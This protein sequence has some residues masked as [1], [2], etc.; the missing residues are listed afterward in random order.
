MTDLPE[1]L[2]KIGLE[3]YGAIFAEHEITLDVLTDLTE[4]DIDRLALPTGPRRQLIVAI[5]AL[6]SERPQPSPSTPAYPNRAIDAER[7]QL[8]VMFCDLAGFTA[9]AE[10]LDPEELRELMNTYRSV[11][12][13]IIDRYEGHVAQYLGDGLMVYFGWPNAHEDDAERCLRA[14]LEIVQAVEGM[15]VKG[16]LEVRIG[17]ATGTVVMGDVSRSAN[18]ETTLAVGETPNLA[19]RLQQSAEPGQIVMGLATRRLLGD[20]VDTTDLG[21]RVLD[22]FA[23]PVRVWRVNGLHRTE[24]RFEAAHE[25]LPL[26]PFVGREEETALLVRAWHQARD[27]EGRVVL[28]GGEPGIGKSRLIQVLRDELGGGSHT[29]LRY[30]CSPFHVNSMLYPIIEHLEFAAGFVRE[31]TADQ[32][33]DKMENVLLGTTPR[34]TE[35]AP[36]MA[37][38]LSLPIDRYGPLDLSPQK[39]KEKTLE[40]L[41]AHIEVLSRRQPLLMVFED[42]HWIDPSSQEALDVL[43]PRL[44][45][46]AVLLVI[47]HRPEYTLRWAQQPHVTRLGLGRLGRRHGAELVAQVTHGRTLPAEVLQQIVAHTDGVPLFIE[48]LTKSVLESGLLRESGIE[49]TL[50]TPL[51]PLAIPTSLRDSL[52]ARL[53]RLAPAKDIIQVGACIGQEFSHDL[54]ARISAIG[55]DVLEE[56]LAKLIE[57]G[58]IYRRGSPPDAIYTFK[59]ALMRDAAYDSLLKSRRVQLHAEIAR[60]LDEHFADRVVNEPER[61]AH[62]HTQSGNLT[63]AIPLWQKA[64]TLALRRVAL[65]EALAHFQNG[66]LLIA[67]LPPSAERDSLELSIREPLNLAWTGLRGWAAPEAADNEVAILDL[68]RR[69]NRPQSLLLGMW[70]MWSH[71]ITRG[72]IAD[73]LEWA[74]RLLDEGTRTHNSDMRIFG[75]TNVAISRFYLGDLTDARDQAKQVLKLYDPREAVRRLELTSLDVRTFVGVWSSQWTWMLGYPDQAVRLSDEK[76]AQARELSNAFNLGFV[77]TLGAYTFDYRSEP[78]RLLERIHEADRVAREQSIP[79]LS[80]VQIPMAE[81]LAWLRSGHLGEAISCLRR[82]IEHWNGRGGHIRI[83]YVKAALAEALARQGHLDSALETIDECL[84]QI[85]RPGWQERSHLAEVLRLKG[86]MLMQKGRGAEAEAP[87]RASIEWARRQRAKSWELRASTT[88]AELLIDRGQADAARKQLAAI[89]DWFTEGFETHDLRSARRM[90]ESLR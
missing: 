20:V 1:W 50:Q 75:H 47:T 55:D 63:A 15:G 61:L 12:A 58:L 68:A 89:Y 36:L 59:H 28:I 44:Q 78:E 16:R 40:A 18:M 42:A 49:Y 9:L 51:P 74:D 56:G 17:I 43:V 83:P 57:A 54:L 45:T 32:K 8:T 70:G 26:T 37:A 29:V 69:Q 48:E 38:L 24:G 34:S 14:A 23:T 52:L 76:D 30:Q 3:R 2:R 82:G 81:G 79:F 11:S 7:R 73:S 27:G 21:T 25:G 80:E 88:L 84:D 72:Q 4:S 35:S 10:R 77:L 5:R 86:W 31:D 53:D 71:T 64:G 62:H 65:Q 22:G 33:L 67:Q 41:A 39:Q 6:Q 60:T 19:A 85:E 13:N 46:L 66:L 87:L 90:L